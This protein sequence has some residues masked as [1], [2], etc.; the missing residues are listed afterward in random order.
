MIAVRIGPDLRMAVVGAPSY[1]ATTA[2][3][4]EA[5]GPD[6][7]RLHQHPPADLWRTL[8]LGIRE[9]R[10]RAEGAGRRAA[11]VQQH[12]AE[13]ERGA[14]RARPRLSARGSGAGRTSPTDGSSACSTTGAR[15]F[16][17]ITST[18]RAA[19]NP[20]RPSPCWSMRCATAADGQPLERAVQAGRNSPSSRCHRM[21][22][23]LAG[24]TSEDTDG[25]F[26]T[27]HLSVRRTRL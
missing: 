16:R 1:F 23:Q 8:R 7:A 19:A 10:P 14:G 9:A 25:L 11:G 15:R 12:R 13:T 4:E 5:A 26:P 18:T 2:A 22:Q 20:R 21:R 6:G 27:L 24:H 17:A 3:A